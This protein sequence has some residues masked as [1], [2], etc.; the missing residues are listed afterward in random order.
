ML[1]KEKE[2]SAPASMCE[3]EEV[4]AKDREVVFVE[5]AMF[6]GVDVEIDL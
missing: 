6:V 2:R 5:M 1:G 3:G 4:P